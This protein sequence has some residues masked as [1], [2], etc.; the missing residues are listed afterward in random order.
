MPPAEFFRTTQADK[1]SAYDEAGLP[2]HDIHGKEL[3]AKARTKLSDVQAKQAK[4][5]EWFLSLGVPVPPA[6]AAAHKPADA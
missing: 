6:P 4:A 1:Y 5:H 2:T 3:S